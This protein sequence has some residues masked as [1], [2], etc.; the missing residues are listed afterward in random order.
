MRSEVVRATHSEWTANPDA[1]R[2][3]PTVSGRLVDGQAELTAGKYTW[4]ADL[5]AALG[6]TGSAPTPTQLLLG[7]LAGCAVALIHDTLAPQ[8]GVELRDVTAVARCTSDARGL[9]G[10]DG[11]RPDLA[12]IEIDVTIDAA[13]PP[14]RLRE[15]EKL[16]Q[17]RCPIYL[18]IAKPNAVSVRVS[19]VGQAPD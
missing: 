11:A 16:W 2:G 9:L 8:L 13:G 5:P 15:L 12:N 14:D 1:A 18:A 6:G 3:A 4:R 10:M 17:E 19:G 7:A